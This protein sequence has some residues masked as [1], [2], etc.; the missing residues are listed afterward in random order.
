M[1]GSSIKTCVLS[2]GLILFWCGVAPG[3]FATSPFASIPEYDLV[4][5]YG[6]F[7]SSQPGK[8]RLELYYK[9]FNSALEF[10]AQKDLF[11]AEYELTVE[12]EDNDGKQVEKITRDKKVAVTADKRAESRLDYRTSQI[13]FDLLPAKYK[14]K[15][16][17]GDKHS[18]RVLTRDFE[19]NL[20]ELR[21]DEPELSRVEFVQAF[22][23]KGPDAS[24][25]DKGNMVVVPS[26]TRDFGG[27]DESSVAYYFEIYPGSE[28]SAKVVV[29]TKVRHSTKGLCYRDTLHVT[30]G[31][32]PERQLREI[33]LEYLPPG[34]CEME[35]IL[36]GRRNKK[37]DEWKEKFDVV[38]SQEAMVRTGWNI[39]V[40]Q[41]ALIAEPG[42][43]DHMKKLE[44]YDERMEALAEFWLARDPIA[45][46][47]INEGKREFYRR[48]AV[49]N[50]S[51]GVMMREGWRTDRGRIYIRYGNPDEIEDEPFSLNS[52]P[53]QIWYYYSQ[54]RY[55]RF[56]FIDENE[57]G[58]Y[59]LQYPYDG[60]YQRP[61]F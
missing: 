52:P 3:Q 11:V 45:G 31:S 48:I 14:V 12:I 28:S 33:S 8:A 29:E 39:T 60:L 22:R 35:V 7:R 34:E 57:D 27:D 42:E 37:L 47:A 54:N 51:F 13:N 40:E 38:W 50:R 61:D 15:V 4:V 23:I 17:L 44:T 49:A 5:D 58:D 6:H 59:R 16:T 46:T 19:V 53:Y 56:V 32:E 21:R 36:R 10:Q 20:D 9:V 1:F 18:S 55:R 41:L 30:L 24:V 25:F 26:V 2:L 43:V